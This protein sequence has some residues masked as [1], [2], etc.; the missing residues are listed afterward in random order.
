ML[1]LILTFNGCS[2]YH[3]RGFQNLLL[4]FWASQE[5]PF[6]YDCTVGSG[7]RVTSNLNVSTEEGPAGGPTAESQP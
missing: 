7:L 1:F 3:S 4:L 5:G 6:Q 2:A